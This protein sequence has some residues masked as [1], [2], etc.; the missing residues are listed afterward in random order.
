MTKSSKAGFTLAEVL[1]TLMVI[2]V[3]AAMTIPTLLNS[4]NEQQFKVAFKKAVSILS[5]GTQLMVAKESECTVTD[6]ATLATCF[7]TNVLSGSGPVDFKGSNEG[8]KNVIPTSDGLAYAFY[9]TGDTTVTTSRSLDSICGSIAD[10][11][12]DTNRS[13]DMKNSY[14]GKGAKCFV[15]VDLNGLTKGSKAFSSNGQTGGTALS[16]KFGNTSKDGLGQGL[17]SASDIGKSVGED[18]AVLMLFG[19]GIR[20]T[21]ADGSTSSISR[22]Y[23]YMYGDADPTSSN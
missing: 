18:Q 10:I 4:T 15:I 13:N 1:T 5:Q 16:G 12:S 20:P 23:T 11:D 17:T 2:G 3:V 6:D 22:G 14:N 7:K 21:Y 8:T 9:F 19:D